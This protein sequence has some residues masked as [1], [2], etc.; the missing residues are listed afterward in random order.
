[1]DSREP[2]SWYL[3]ELMSPIILIEKYQ[4][5][6]QNNLDFKSLQNESFNNQIDKYT[7]TRLSYFDW[8]RKK[9]REGGRKEILA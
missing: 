6:K 1:M 3:L 8:R 2:C 9:G 5:D 7:S 4:Y